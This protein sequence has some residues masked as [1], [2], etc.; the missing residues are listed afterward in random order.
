MLMGAF[1]GAVTAHLTGTFLWAMACHGLR[2]CA[3]SCLCTGRH[4]LSCR[5]DGDR[6][7]IISSAIGLTS[8]LLRGL[9][10]GKARLSASPSCPHGRFRPVADSVLGPLLFNHPPITMLGF[11][12]VFPLSFFMFRTRRA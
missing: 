6:P 8:F 4:A 10:D 12:L 7:C 9:F 2:Q 3:G 1:G 5:P 11:L